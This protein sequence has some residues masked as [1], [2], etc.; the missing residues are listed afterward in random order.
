MKV[1]N[2][3]C[4]PSEVFRDVVSKNGEY[5]RITL[6]QLSHK[7]RTWFM[8]ISDTSGDVVFKTRQEHTNAQKMLKIAEEYIS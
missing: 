2:G 3:G 5:Y 8:T 4:T 1:I 6:I 7:Y